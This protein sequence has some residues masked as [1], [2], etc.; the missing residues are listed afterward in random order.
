MYHMYL[1]THECKKQTNTHTHTHT[2]RLNPPGGELTVGFRGFGG[3]GSRDF[4]ARLGMGRVLG[5]A[6]TRSAA[7]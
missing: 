1:D 2:Q 4:V 5:V 3:S 6:L 7:R